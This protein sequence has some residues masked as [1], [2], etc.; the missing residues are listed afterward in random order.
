MALQIGVLALQGDF[1]LHAESI[2]RTGS[3][4]MEVRTVEDLDGCDALVIPGG[5]STVLAKLLKETGLDRGV[6]RFS[7]NRPVMGTC[8]G[9]IVLSSRVMDHSIDPL[10]LIDIT[11]ERNAYGRQADSFISDVAL[12]TGSVSGNF[13]GVFIRAPKITDMGKDIEVLGQRGDDVVMVRN[14]GVLVAAFHPELT[15]D[16]RIHSYFLRNFL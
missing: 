14:R 13:E 4:S 16:N 10:G 11:V 9:L 1:A 5:E 15:M 3:D 6:V 7:D 12:L 2:R 8:A